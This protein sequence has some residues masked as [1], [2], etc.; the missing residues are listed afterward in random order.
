MFG[1]KFLQLSFEDFFTRSL[2]FDGFRFKSTS[3]QMADSLFRVTTLVK[4]WQTLVSTGCFWNSDV[5]RTKPQL[6]GVVGSLVQIEQLLGQLWNMNLKIG[7][8][9]SI[10]KIIFSLLL[11]Q[12][13]KYARLVC[14]KSHK[15]SQRPRNLQK[16]FKFFAFFD[17]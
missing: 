13:C 15:N 7:W 9:K 17:M 12:C 14:R 16:V 5:Q 6:P 2:K 8:K 3:T 11:T 4:N 1:Y 10:E